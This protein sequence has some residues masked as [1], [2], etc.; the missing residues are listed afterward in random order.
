MFSCTA[1]RR[2]DEL[3]LRDQAIVTSCHCKGQLLWMVEVPNG[4]SLSR[5]F[6]LLCWGPQDEAHVGLTC[7]STQHA[8]EGKLVNGELLICITNYTHT[9]VRCLFTL[10]QLADC[11]T[12]IDGFNCAGVL[13]SESKAW[14]DLDVMIHSCQGT[15]TLQDQATVFNTHSRKCIFALSSKAT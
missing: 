2:F 1:D 15:K 11:N 4:E 12:V 6:C 7:L 10:L 8:D 5:F 13:D 3:V 9:F 14:P